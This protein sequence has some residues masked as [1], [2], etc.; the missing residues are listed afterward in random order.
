MS[1]I[2]VFVV[3]C[4]TGH[5]CWLVL[6]RHEEI[7]KKKNTGRVVFYPSFKYLAGSVWARYCSRGAK[8][9]GEKV[10]SRGGVSGKNAQL[11][12]HDFSHSRHRAA[13]L[14]H[15]SLSRSL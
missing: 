10:E 14:P 13:A 9:K 7:Y 12:T 8:V 3:A 4:G 15:T 5:T 1:Q 2:A 6:L 11:V